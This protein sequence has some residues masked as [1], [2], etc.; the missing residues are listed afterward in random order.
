[1]NKTGCI[2]PRFDVSLDGIE[3]WTANLL[4]SRQFGYLVLTT[5]EGIMD[6]EEARR[7][8]TG[9]KVCFSSQLVIYVSDSR[10]FLLD[11]I[12]CNLCRKGTINYKFTLQS[13]LSKT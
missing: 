10:I 2:S 8:G 1:M 13:V 11:G 7:K 4:P 5:S 9:G 12:Q 6:H 3:G